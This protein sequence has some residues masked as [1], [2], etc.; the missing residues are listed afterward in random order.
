MREITSAGIEGD[1]KKK[2]KGGL[3]A[4]VQTNAKANKHVMDENGAVNFKR[5]MIQAAKHNE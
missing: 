1:E 5:E 2:R 3:E 4:G